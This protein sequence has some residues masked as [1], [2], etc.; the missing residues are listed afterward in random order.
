M[1]SWWIAN[2]SNS[3]S[4][5][6][7]NQVCWRSFWQ[8]I[9]TQ[10]KL[11]ISDQNFLLD[12]HLKEKPSCKDFV[13]N[14]PQNDI[15][16]NHGAYLTMTRTAVCPYEVVSVYM[17][18][19]FR[20]FGCPGNNNLWFDIPVVYPTLFRPTHSVNVVDWSRFWP[21]GTCEIRQRPNLSIILV[22]ANLMDLCP[23]P[24]IP[25]GLL[26]HFGP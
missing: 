7:M 3:R 16:G 14:M 22:P 8:R 4:A 11:Q 1:R 23:T 21:Q 12:F 9:H 5:M 24:N 17:I 18:Y 26:N 13:N 15:H 19:M 25:I 20:S 10:V 2:F 6:S